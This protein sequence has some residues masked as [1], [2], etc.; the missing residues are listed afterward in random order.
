MIA[1]RGLFLGLGA[2]LAA[3]AIVR[4]GLLMPIKPEVPVTWIYGATYRLQPDG[5]YRP[6]ILQF[7]PGA[8]DSFDAARLSFLEARKTMSEGPYRFDANGDGTWRRVSMPPLQS[9]AWEA[10][11]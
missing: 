2:M 4:P 10:F 5:S 9:V 8:F 3:P 6:D 1:R 11:A 7:K